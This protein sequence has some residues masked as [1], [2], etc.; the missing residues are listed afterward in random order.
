MLLSLFLILIFYLLIFL[1]SYG[2]HFISV[3][4]IS[5]FTNSFSLNTE[6]LYRI[7]AVYSVLR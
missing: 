5:L 1:D 2:R 7:S 6:M 4:V 3:K